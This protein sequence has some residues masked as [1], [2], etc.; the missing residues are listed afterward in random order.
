MQDH[1]SPFH[2]LAQAVF[3]SDIDERAIGTARSAL[4]TS[5]IIADVSPERIQQ[6]FTKEDDRYRIR[7]SIRDQVLFA[8]H[9]VLRDPRFS[10]L[11]LIPVAIC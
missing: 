10:K 1:F 9:N 6:Y 3:A 5:S 2:G 8:P 4:Y 7:K 11:D